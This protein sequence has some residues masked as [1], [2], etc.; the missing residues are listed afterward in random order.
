MR[1]APARRVTWGE[2]LSHPEVKE[3]SV[4]GGR[5]GLMAFHGG[6]EPGTAE[7]AEAAAVASGASLYVVEQPAALRWHVP[8]HAITPERSALLRGWLAHV[9]V[10][11]ALHG[12]G[13]LHQPRRILLGGRNRMLAARLATCLGNRLPDLSVVTDMDDIPRELRGL[14]RDNPVNRPPSSG[15]QV[16][17]P[18][19]ARDRR[20]DPRAPDQVTEALAEVIAQYPK[21]TP[22]LP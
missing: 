13:R 8:S 15:V 20:L 5:F 12:Y 21:A 10:V 7:I 18:P 4:I 16:E 14:H 9:D 17:L 3:R 22:H 19:S 2:L 1:S 11:I 6:L